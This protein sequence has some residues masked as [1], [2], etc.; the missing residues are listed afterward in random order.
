MAEGTT[1]QFSPETL[2][3]LVGFFDILVEMDLAQPSEDLS[4]SQS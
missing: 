4:K 2:A 1:L 3:N